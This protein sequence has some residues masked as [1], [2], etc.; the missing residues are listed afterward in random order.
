MNYKYNFPA[1]FLIG[2]TASGKTAASI[3]IA[4]NL[5]SNPN[6]LDNKKVRGIIKIHDKNAINLKVKRLKPKKMKMEAQIPLLKI[7]KSQFFLNLAHSI[8]I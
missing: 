7:I 3:A 4:E 5:P 8:Y 1:I 2:P 6:F